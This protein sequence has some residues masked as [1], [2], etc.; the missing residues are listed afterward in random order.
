[1]SGTWEVSQSLRKLRSN[2]QSKRRYCKGSEKSDF[3]IV[4]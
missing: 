3:L 4:L 1:M 2:R